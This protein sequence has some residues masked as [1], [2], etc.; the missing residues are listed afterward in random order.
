MARLLMDEYITQASTVDDLAARLTAVEMV[1]LG[2][3]RSDNGKRV[4]L[5]ACGTLKKLQ[6]S[7][8]TISQSPVPFGPSQQELFESGSSFTFIRGTRNAQTREVS[9]R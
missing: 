8:V 3:I 2:Q 7:N 6:V 1:C 5:F 4:Q 9:G